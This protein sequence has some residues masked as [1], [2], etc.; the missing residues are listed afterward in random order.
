MKFNYLTKK[1]FKSSSTNKIS[2][3]S[4][5]KFRSLTTSSLR[6]TKNLTRLDKK[7]SNL[8]LKLNKFNK[9]TIS[10]KRLKT[11]GKSKLSL[12]AKNIMGLWKISTTNLIAHYLTI[13]AHN[14]LWVK[15]LQLTLTFHTPNSRS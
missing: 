10:L 4:D 12:S 2:E 15:S 1:I 7:I 14:K 8:K 5:K 6:R 9:I 13:R 3:S 11:C